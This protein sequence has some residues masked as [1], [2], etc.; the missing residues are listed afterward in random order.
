[1]EERPSAPR[2]LLAGTLKAGRRL[3]LLGDRSPPVVNVTV[4]LLA[5]GADAGERLVGRCADGVRKVAGLP[6]PWL[7]DLVDT[8]AEHGESTIADSTRQTS[9]WF[10]DAVNDSI[11]RATRSLL[12]GVVGQVVRQASETLAPEVIDAVLPRIRADTVPLIIGDVVAD[13][14]IRELIADQ[15]RTIMTTAASELQNKMAAADV[16]VEAAFRRLRGGGTAT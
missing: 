9:A 15:G 10:K 2:L 14:R 12:G 8:A 11:T 7:R 3:R 1:M 16:Q 4:G 6:S 5:Q 13:P